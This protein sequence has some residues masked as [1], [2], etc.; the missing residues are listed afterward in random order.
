MPH[1]RAPFTLEAWIRPR[2]LNGN[3]R[4]VFSSEGAQGGWLLGVRDT[5]L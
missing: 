5:G 4:R 2:D 1:G 3:T